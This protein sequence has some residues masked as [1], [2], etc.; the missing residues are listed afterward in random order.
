MSNL[1]IELTESISLSETYTFIYPWNAS[2]GE[3]QITAGFLIFIKNEE[4]N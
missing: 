2:L 4:G 1:N 3:A